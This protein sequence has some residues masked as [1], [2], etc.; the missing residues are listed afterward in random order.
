LIAPAG[1]ELIFQWTKET[2]FEDALRYSLLARLVVLRVPVLQDRVIRALGQEREILGHTEAEVDLDKETVRIVHGNETEARAFEPDVKVFVGD[3]AVEDGGL[4]LSLW[5]IARDAPLQS[6]RAAYSNLVHGELWLRLVGASPEEARAR[7]ESRWE[8]LGM[9]FVMPMLYAI[10]DNYSES[11]SA[12]SAPQL[13]RGLSELSSSTA[14]RDGARCL[15]FLARLH[16][17]DSELPAEAARA[18]AR[19]VKTIAEAHK[20]GLDEAQRKELEAALER[21]K[22][23]VRTAS[24]LGADGTEAVEAEI[25]EAEGM[26]VAIP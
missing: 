14:L 22:G 7:F 18:E 10:M 12:E 2:L 13:A 20:A 23:L 9:Q 1:E 16:P 26:L 17:N 6:R 11:E 19:W 3:V 24:A 21:G 15:A 5:G 4:R 8:E 25:V